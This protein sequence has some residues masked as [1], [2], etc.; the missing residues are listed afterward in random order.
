MKYNHCLS[1]ELFIFELYVFPQPLRF[2]CGSVYEVCPKR[3]W[4]AFEMSL[5]VVGKEK[6]LVKC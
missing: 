4:T 2:F 6:K 5:T 1:F 3:L